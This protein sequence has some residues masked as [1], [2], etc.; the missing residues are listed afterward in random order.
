M[1]KKAQE[2][3][4]KQVDW[5]RGEVEEYEVGNMVLLSTGDLKW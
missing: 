3:I 4:K 5:H 2:E 1:L